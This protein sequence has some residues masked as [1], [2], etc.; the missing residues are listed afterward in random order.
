MLRFGTQIAKISNRRKY[1]L[2]GFVQSEFRNTYWLWSTKHDDNDDGNQDLFLR[3]ICL[4][5][6]QNRLH[7]LE[8]MRRK[9]GL[10]QDKEIYKNHSMGKASQKL[11]QTKVGVPRLALLLGQW[12]QWRGREARRVSP[13]RPWGSFPNQGTRTGTSTGSD[14]MKICTGLGSTSSLR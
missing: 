14:R 2:Y 8:K 11:P 7:I 9:S 6:R 4:I 5:R 12:P 10:L 3:S 1:P 13:S